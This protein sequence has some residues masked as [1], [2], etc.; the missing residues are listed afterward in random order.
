MTRKTASAEVLVGVRATYL[1]RRVKGP[2][3]ILAMRRIHGGLAPEGRVHHAKQ[4][5]GDGNPGDAPHERGRRESH[6][7][8]HHPT[9]QG[10][11]YGTP[12]GA[13]GEE[14]VFQAFLGAARLM[15]FPALETQDRHV[16]RG[17]LQR[18]DEGVKELQ[19]PLL[20]A[21]DGRLPP[22]ATASWIEAGAK[23]SERTI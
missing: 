10:D 11:E 6:Q 15:A 21:Q 3:G 19:E 12:V 18:F 13:H 16:W 7:I 14:G 20:R 4:G 22:E 1:G 5:R 23:V 8:R 17:P 2:D 9:P